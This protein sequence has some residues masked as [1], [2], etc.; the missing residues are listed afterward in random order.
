[1]IDSYVNEAFRLG[2]DISGFFGRPAAV[3]VAASIVKAFLET[4]FEGGRHVARVDKMMRLEAAS[5]GDPRCG[6]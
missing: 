6:C 2:T 3:G 5:P 1:M 4:P